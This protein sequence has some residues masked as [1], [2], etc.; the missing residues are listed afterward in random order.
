MWPFFHLFQNFKRAY[1]KLYSKL[2]LK[3]FFTPITHKKAIQRL[4]GQHLQ[5]FFS[6]EL[7]VDFFWQIYFRVHLY[8]KNTVFYYLVDVMPMMKCKDLSLLVVFT[9]IMHV[10]LMCTLI[11]DF[12]GTNI[13]IENNKYVHIINFEMI[14]RLW[15]STVCKTTFAWTINDFNF[16]LN[17][18]CVY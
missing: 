15:Y 8:C 9:D 11:N 10:L 12:I 13:C 14:C 2:Q 17:L 16:Y 5:D 3:T 6:E 18:C 7:F 4:S 1:L